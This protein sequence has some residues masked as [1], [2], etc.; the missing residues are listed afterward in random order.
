MR[1]R[2]CRLSDVILSVPLTAS[3]DDI[4]TEV[5]KNPP[6]SDY[7]SSIG[8]SM[9]SYSKYVFNETAQSYKTDSTDPNIKSY[10]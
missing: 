6:I 7:R 1:S 10:Q 8:R 2:S 9:D 3:V 4:A 5:T